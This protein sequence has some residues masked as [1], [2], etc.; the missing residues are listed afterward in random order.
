M[1]SIENTESIERRMFRLLVCALG[2]LLIFA[3]VKGG[4]Q[5]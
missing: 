5:A 4:P 1:K 3:L 2:L